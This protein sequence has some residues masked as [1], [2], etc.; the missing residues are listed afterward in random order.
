ME[1]SEGNRGGRKKGSLFP[2]LYLNMVLEECFQIGP[3]ELID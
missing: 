1:Q 3:N 2:F